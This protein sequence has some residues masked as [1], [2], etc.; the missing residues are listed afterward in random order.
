MRK[1]LSYF[2]V[3]V[4]TVGVFA[5]SR[6]GRGISSAVFQDGLGGYVGIVDTFI[7]TSDPSNSYGT[8]E[9]VLWNT[10]D[11]VGMFDSWVELRVKSV[12]SPSFS[13]KNRIF[14]LKFG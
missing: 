4:V 11:P 13:L 14:T 9:Y 8:L 7:K 6:S 10:D 12:R 2:I 1:T 5:Q 3:L